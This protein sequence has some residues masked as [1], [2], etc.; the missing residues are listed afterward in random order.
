MRR[1]LVAAFVG[2]TVLVVA[3][4]GIPRAF[5]LSDLVRIDEQAR[6]DRTADV[7]ALL[8]DERLA[9]GRGVTAD[10]LDSVAAPGEGLRVSGVPDGP[11]RT[12]TVLGDP[13][14]S[15]QASRP[16]AGG[17]RVTVTRSG[18]AV[19]EELAEALLP[20]ALLGLLLAA[21]AA[22]A[23]FLLAER[24]ARP[25]RELAGTARRLGEGRL[26]PDVPTYDVPEADAIGRA[27]VEAGRRL[28]L[29]LA[30]ERRVA[31]HASHELR[32]PLT[33]LRL[34]L[35]DL[36]LGPDVSP[37]VTQGLH[38]GVAE[39][40]RLS[41]A[42]TDLLELADSHRAATEAD[43]D[44]E[45]LVAEAVAR[46][47]A[48]G[49]PV[50]HEPSQPA[51]TRFDPL[52][53]LQALD[54]LVEEALAAGAREA[55]VSVS[56]RPTHLELRVSG[57]ARAGDGTGGA[58]ERLTRAGELAAT[59]GGQVARDGTTLVLRLPRRAPLGSRDSAQ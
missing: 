56:A 41:A 31:V 22:L 10:Y 44:L 25:F 59:A 46:R 15:I 49:V 2:L 9:D 8:L 39:L 33:A 48:E 19:A 23:S 7:L 50:A 54:L 21:L 14:G 37:A 26:H 57:A 34:E 12:S 18:E 58:P 29:L 53:V 30:Q 51:P 47:R 52:P 17:G 1:R 55:T 6:V 16:L 11:V 4:Y 43:V 42:V 24:L 27:L 3:L 13:D 35:E 28:D 36:A 45:T 20:L 40:D 38:H 5:L 32:T